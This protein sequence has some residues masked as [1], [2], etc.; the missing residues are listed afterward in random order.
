[1]ERK[2]KGKNVKEKREEQPEGATTS[3]ADTAGNGDQPVESLT[4]EEVEALRSELEEYRVKAEDHLDGWQRA[5]AEFANYRKRVERDQQ[6]VYQSAAARILR[7]FLEISDDL[8]RALQN[9]PQEG[10]GAEWANGIE[11][12]YRKL[13]SFL[14]AEGV[15]RIDAL[16]KPFDPQ[17]H[18]AIDQDESDEYE[19]DHVIEVVQAG[20][21]LGDQ[22]LRPALVRVAR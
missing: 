15:R 14:E 10:P 7:R 11:L 3:A 18:E 12:I 21:L 6:A 4:P 17:L 22:V 1:M 13:Q 16:G 2:R 19:S 9:R 5:L 8:E 20:Y